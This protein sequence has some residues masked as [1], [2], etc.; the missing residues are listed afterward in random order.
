MKRLC[1]LAIAT[2]VASTAVAQVPGRV[3]TATR[4][5]VIFSNLENQLN[6]AVA[7][8]NHQA[9]DRLLTEDFEEW[10]P[11]P[12]G[13]PVPRQEWLEK[14]G[15]QLSNAR[16]LQMA[17]KG[18]DDHA[19]ANFVLVTGSKSYFVVD[20]WQKQGDDWKLQQRYLCPVDPTLYVQPAHP[21]GKD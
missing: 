8:G 14:S 6:D 3:Q 13:S 7:T 2:L 9:V 21:A 18:L 5:V 19:L 12:P 16:L 4:L 15:K 11:Q 20:A 17:V 10:T 1:I